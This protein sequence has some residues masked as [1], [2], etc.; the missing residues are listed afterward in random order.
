MQADSNAQSTP[1]NAQQEAQ[2]IS[3]QQEWSAD[4][5]LTVVNKDFSEWESYRQQN[6]DKRFQNSDQLFLAWCPQKVWDGTRIP[7]SSLGSFLTM[8]QEETLL[9]SIMAAIFPLED[10]VQPQP[11]FGTSM[12]QARLAL[13]LILEQMRNCDDGYS[14]VREVIR[15]TFKQG[16]L[17]GNGIMEVSWQYMEQLKNIAVPVW[18]SGNY[19]SM[20]AAM[21]GSAPKRHLAVHPVTYIKNQPLLSAIDIRDFYID[22]QTNCPNIQKARGCAVRQLVTKESLAAYRNL[23]GFDVPSDLGLK[24]LSEAKTSTVGDQSKQVGESYRQVTYSATNDYTGNPNSRRLELIRHFNH[25]RVTWVLNRKWVMY[26]AANDLGCL[27]FLNSFYIDVPNQFY[28][29]SMADVCEPEQRLQQSVI[30]ARVDE[31]AITINSPFVM[32][33]GDSLQQGALRMVPGKVLQLESPDSFKKM[34]W[35][36]ITQN[37]YMEVSA[38]EQRNQKTTGLTDTASF[39]VGSAGGNSANRTATGVN[40]Q[41]QA[42]GKRIAGIVNNLDSCFIEPLFDMLHRYNKTF[43]SPEQVFYLVG[44]PQGIDPLAIIHADVRFKSQA[45]RKMQSRA[46]ILQTMPQLLPF[47]LNPEVMTLLA[48][49]SGQV[50]DIKAVLD[51]ISDALNVGEMQW[52]RSMNPQEQQQQMMMNPNIIKAQTA[53]QMQSQRL[54]AQGQHQDAAGDT[55][56][57]AAVMPIFAANHGVQKQA[58]GFDPEPPQKPAAKKK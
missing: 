48:Q 31:L 19:N 56:L 3:P 54:E 39:G 7:R 43:L 23:P 55:K 4:Y 37:A 18:D 13:M 20:Y 52:F 40:S 24:L 49:Q 53:Q 14:S 5:A 15:R 44:I 9:D 33:R 41:V 34:E 35:P 27:P 16:F 11:M 25:D 26:R 17:Y 6:H 1:F 36:N 2:V 57:L 12:F 30:N 42:A 46:M 21:Y 58:T 50:L 8:Q 29:L 51:D 10:N 47:L 38:S 28:G 45:G 32:K 22:P